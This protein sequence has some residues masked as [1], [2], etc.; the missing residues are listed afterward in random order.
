MTP[1]KTLT[2]RQVHEAGLEDWR[3]LLSALSARFKTGDFATG[4]RLVN[5]IGAAAETMNHHPDVDLRYTHV[6]V[7]LTSHDSG[8]VTERDLRL[9]RTISELAAAESV[10]SA[11]AE[12][13]AIEIAL[14]T[15]DAERIQPFWAAVLGYTADDGSAVS[16]PTGALPALW[17]QD[18]DNDAADRQ[19]FH[20]DLIVPPEVV[21][22]RIAEAVEAGGTLV[23]DEHA[24]SFWVLADAE[25]NKVCL[26]TWQGRDDT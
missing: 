23:T 15:P 14:D 24:P 5:A 6:D 26:C 4:L 13:A 8:G 1:S 16:D 11:P 21:Q 19:R 22:D 12:V 17:F 18:T 2:G 3:L 9:A 10:G 20:L 7:R 25:G